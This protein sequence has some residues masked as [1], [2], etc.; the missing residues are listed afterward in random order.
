MLARRMTDMWHCCQQT[1]TAASPAASAIPC[2][3]GQAGPAARAREPVT[4][5]QLAAQAP[6]ESPPR[7]AAQGRL[8]CV[9]EAAAR[10]GQG[11]PAVKAAMRAFC[12]SHSS[13]LS[14][15]TGQNGQK[16]VRKRRG[17]ARFMP[18]VW[19]WRQQQQPYRT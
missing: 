4:R 9:S 14:C 18:D 5:A 11:L 6:P 8:C 3:A 17:E 7:G 13:I 10:S 19:L 2:R 12:R 15:R 16:T 1:G